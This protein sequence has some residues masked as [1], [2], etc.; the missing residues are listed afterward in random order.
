MQKITIQ[1]TSKLTTIWNYLPYALAI[2]ACCFSILAVIYYSPKLNAAFTTF[3]SQNLN[4]RVEH[5]Y[6]TGTNN[7]NIKNLRNAIEIKKDQPIFSISTNKIRQQ[8]E[9]LPWVRLAQVQRILPNSLKIKIIEQKAIATI[10]FN[11]NRWALNSKGE[12]IDIVDD[13]FN[14]L[15]EL[16]GPQAKENAASLFSLFSEWPEMLFLV[17]QAEFIGKRRWNLY[18]ENGIIIMLPEDGVRH[19]LKVLKA[20]NQQQRILTKKQIKVDLRNVTKH[21][22]IDEKN[23]TL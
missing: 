10:K 23:Q 7:V 13:K 15:L 22:I 9:A 5:M 4:L 21:I 14:H 12:L 6:I 19:A 11:E 2:L 17:K 1:K 3:L 8:V 16:S 18:L 20:L